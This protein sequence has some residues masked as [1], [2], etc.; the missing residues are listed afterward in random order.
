MDTLV[1]Q[2]LLQLAA[3]VRLLGATTTLIGIRPEVAQTLVSPG[4]DFP[5]VRM[6]ATLQEGPAGI[7]K[8][9]AASICCAP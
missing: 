2:A 9:G 1:A 6:S 3:A 4:A 7:G 8:V 5:Q